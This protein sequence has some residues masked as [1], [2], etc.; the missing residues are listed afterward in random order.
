VF[1][2]PPHGSPRNTMQVTISELEPREDQ[3]RLRASTR[4]GQLVTAD[5]TAPAVSELGLLPGTTV[6]FS[7]KASAVTVYPG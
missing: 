1:T 5:V 6:Y 3:V 2:E 4:A 7:L